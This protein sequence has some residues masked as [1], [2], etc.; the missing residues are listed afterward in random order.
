MAISPID[1]TGESIDAK[2]GDQFKA[3]LRLSETYLDKTPRPTNT[4]PL[5]SRVEK[6]LTPEEQQTFLTE[7][8]HLLVIYLSSNRN[9]P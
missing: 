5:S 6:E 3:H 9:Y 2:A 8:N 7:G 4:R 1:L